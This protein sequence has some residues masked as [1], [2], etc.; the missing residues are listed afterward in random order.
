MQQ[1][2]NYFQIITPCSSFLLSRALEVSSALGGPEL[3]PF[4]TLIEGGREGLF[5]AE[6]E[7]FFYYA[8]I[9][10]YIFFYIR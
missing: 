8:Q 7:E 3:E 2:V 6:L 1:S 10:K 4:Y 9:K 5:F